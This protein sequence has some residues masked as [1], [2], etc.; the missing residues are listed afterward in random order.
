MPRKKSPYAKLPPRIFVTGGAGF[1]G[2][3]VVKRLVELGR[4]VVCLVLPGDTARA[5]DGVSY[6]RVTG[7]LSSEDKLAE[8]MAGCDLVIHL[9]AI[10]AL[11]LKRP[12]MMYEVN[13]VG[14]AN[15]MNAAR[16]AGVKRVVHTS[17]IAAVGI[18][19]GKAVSDET[20]HFNDWN[21]S[22]PYVF[23]KYISE[24]EALRHNGNG[25][26]VVAV[27]PA[28]PFGADDRAPTPT[29]K[30]IVNALTGKT[31]FTLNGGFNAVFVGDVAEGHLLAAVKGTP[32]ERYLLSGHNV[33]YDEFAHEL[34]DLAGRRAPSLTVPN[35]LA[36]GMGW[37]AEQVADNV[38][39]KP[40]I[41][42]YRSIGYIAG[43]H[44]YFSSE[45]AQRELGYPVTPLRD[46]LRPAL[47]WFEPRL[48]QF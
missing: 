19:P 16:R 26:E 43:R 42:T 22:D 38:T 11:W 45:K 27:N 23:S 24:L 1:I 30:L 9:A 13:V 4:E 5:L 44:L 18:L 33:T 8:A 6:E 15:L 48:S 47:D 36:K 7:D 35:P 40:P 46:A 2:S 12:E 3:H 17:S 28:F 34:A 21:D 32:G 10:Y 29:G 31:P 37:L 25:L 14:T 20:T 41:A 39:Q